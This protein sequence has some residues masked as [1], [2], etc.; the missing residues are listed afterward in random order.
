MPNVLSHKRHSPGRGII[1]PTHLNAIN[2][3]PPPFYQV[4][5]QVRKSASKTANTKI[6]QGRSVAIYFSNGKIG[7]KLPTI[8]IGL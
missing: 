8:K 4:P 3:P 1:M 2:A 5:T 7:R 6:V